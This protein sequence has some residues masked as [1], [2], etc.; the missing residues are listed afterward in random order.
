[1]GKKLYGKGTVVPTKKGSG[2]GRI[3][4]MAP[5]FRPRKQTEGG[6]CSYQFGRQDG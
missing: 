1:L 3:H 5:C 4:G 2:Y 6:T